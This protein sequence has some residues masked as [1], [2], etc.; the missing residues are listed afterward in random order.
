MNR[1]K[2]VLLVFLTLLLSVMLISC[3]KDNNQFLRVT[4][5]YKKTYYLNEEFSKEGMIVTYVDG[6]KEEI[7]NDYQ[8]E[9]FNSSVIGQ[10]TITISYLELEVKVDLSI[11]SGIQTKT[12]LKI[13]D[14]PEILDSSDRYAV[15][16]ENTPLFVHETLVN[17]S[18]TFTWVPPTTKAAVATFDFLGK[19][20]VR[21]EI[22]DDF[23]VTK[24]TVHPEIYGIEVSVKDNV[25]E[26]DLEFPTNYTIY[27]NDPVPQTGAS[28]S[29]VQEVIH[30]FAN[31]IEEDPI[32]EEEAKLD[33]NIL[34]IGPGIWKADTIPVK[35][36]QTV[37]LAGGS[38]VFGQFNLYEQEDIVIRGRGIISGSIYPRVEASQR[39]IPIEIQRSKN[40]KIEGITFLDP[41]GW[42]LHIQESNNIDI[43]NVKIITAR[44]NGDGISIQSSKD[45]NVRNSFV[46]AWDDALV[47]K[48]TNNKPTEDITFNNIILWSD[49]AQAMEVGYEAYGPYMNN[50]VFENITVLQSYHKAAMSIHNADQADI[51]NVVFKNITI[52]NTYQVGDI[53][54]EDYDNFLI[55]L[56][57]A[58]NADW[59]KSEYERGTISDVYFENIKILNEKKIGR[60][61][62]D[63]RI[64]MNG[65]DVSKNIENVNFK[66]V[67]F[68]GEPIKNTADININN[69]VSNVNIISS[70]EPT[71]APKYM[72]YELELGDYYIVDKVVIPARDQT[73]IEIPEFA[74]SNA[75]PPYAG[76]KIEGDFTARA[77][78]GVS[79]QDWGATTT[80]DYSKEGFGV[81][82][83]FKDDETSFMAKDWPQDANRQNYIA[84][85]IMFNDT[86]K[87][88]SLRLFGDLDSNY[89][90]MQNISVYAAT[91][92][93]SVTG[94]PVFS[95][96]LNGEDYEFSPSNNN[97]VDIRLQPGD[98]IAIQLRFHYQKG[99]I[100]TNNPFIRY[101]EFYPASLTYGKTPYAS[102]Y[103]DVYNTE[104]LTDGDLNS[105]FESK[106]NVWPGWVVVDMGET[107]NVRIIN[108]HLPPLSSWPKRTQRIEIKYSLKS[109]TS[110]NSNTWISLLDGPQDYLFDN[111]NGNLVSIELEQGVEMQSIILIFTANSAPGGY[112]A[113]LSEISIYE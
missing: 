24:A 6:D 35:N 51:T 39:A 8:I 80:L 100:Y 69:F 11:V 42:V 94:Q 28:K 85:S 53:W 29:V 70:N 60:D 95:K 96:R 54:T 48:S 16:V 49:L 27:L 62:Y 112:G 90:Y 46:R 110:Y 71:G 21:V 2:K 99:V 104:K 43:D 10:N 56:T 14:M 38:Y 23:K 102:Q 25:V 41:A 109:E 86:F 88:G 87:V 67:T 73:A 9:G 31:P 17:H 93:H 3:K 66:D 36:G 47:V 103:E 15:Y 106:R 75:T 33:D 44:P 113:Q 5:D 13:Y 7:V 68:K 63:L 79:P 34:Y 77:T 50:I 97:F 32:T 40:I 59:S 108:L 81:S 19:V 82:N 65:F 12:D 57:I 89:F 74:I 58:Y 105:Y 61:D 111:A 76:T 107:F 98:Y 4:G 18:R 37:Y 30:L 101:M 92:L 20:K 1:Y 55:D 91:N 78:L 52:E 64:R 22:K 26:F 84:L 45:V 83:I 72:Y